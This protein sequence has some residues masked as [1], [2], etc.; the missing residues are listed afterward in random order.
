MAHAGELFGRQ[1]RRD[2]P[3]RVQFILRRAEPHDAP[4]F[5]TFPWHIFY[6]VIW[7]G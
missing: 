7:K 1:T 6:R 5:S 4:R 2:R 3:Q